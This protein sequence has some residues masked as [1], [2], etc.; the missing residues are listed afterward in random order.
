MMSLESDTI[1]SHRLQN[2]PFNESIV[3]LNPKNFV[4]FELREYARKNDHQNT[5]TYSNI[6]VTP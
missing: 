5:P 1:P 2:A 6:I 4:K 3:V